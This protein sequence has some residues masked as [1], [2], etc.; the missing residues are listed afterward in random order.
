VSPERVVTVLA[1]IG[2][3]ARTAPIP[4]LEASDRWTSVVEIAVRHR[5]AQLLWQA[6]SS[7]PEGAVP[8]HAL[9]VL[10]GTWFQAAATRLLC[11]STLQALLA[12]VGAT[13]PQ[14]LVL[15]GVSV[16]HALYPSPELRV[17]NDIDILCR[18]GDYPLLRATLLAAGFSG[19]PFQEHVKGDGSH[20]VLGAKPS[21]S[22]SHEVRSFLDPSGDVKVEVHFDIL[23]LGLVDRHGVEYWRRARTLVVGA[24]EVPVLAPEHQFLQLATHALRHSFSELRWLIDLDLLLRQQ[25]DRIDWRAVIDVARDEGVG[26]VV[27]RVLAVLHDVLGTPLPPLPVPSLEERMLAP[28]YRVLWPLSTVR[29]LE[30]RPHPGLIV[31]RPEAGHLRRVTSGLILVGRRLEKLH[32]LWK[33]HVARQATA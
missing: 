4:A 2:A 25:G 18:P 19:V 23:Q 20:E 29:G 22:E 9:G 10:R 31:Y 27:R 1:Q 5:V 21:P 30:Q 33:R 26:P 7:A 12:A 32:A 15:K 11:E 6:L 14:I 16:A 8:A 24:M 28:L 3:G 13:G 17:S